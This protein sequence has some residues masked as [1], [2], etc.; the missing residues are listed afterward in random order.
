MKT[1]HK[2]LTSILSLFVCVSC[3]PTGTVTQTQ[4]KT[5]RVQV[6]TNFDNTPSF[7]IKQRLAA[8]IVTRSGDLTE[9]A[10]NR[11]PLSQAPSDAQGGSATPISSDGYFLTAS[12]VVNRSFGQHI[13]VVYSGGGLVRIA[14]ARVIWNSTKDD[15]A[16]IHVPINTPYFY[17]WSTNRESLVSGNMVYNGGM[18]WKKSYTNMPSSNV[19]GSI[20]YGWADSKK[21][22]EQGRLSISVKSDT[23]VTVNQ[24]FDMGMQVH[25]GDSGGPI[26]DSNG[27]LVGVNSAVQVRGSGKNTTFVNSVGVRPSITKITQLIQSDRS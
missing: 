5:Y 22:P 8:V 3:A 9:W 11:F 25:P 24:K 19:D 1:T 14:R 27:Q 18:H 26:V 21:N 7:A 17:R 23:P 12:H 4:H 10:E 16:L 6:S 15:L 2:L 20:I 13:Y